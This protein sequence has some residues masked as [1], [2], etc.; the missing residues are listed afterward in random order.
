MTYSQTGIWPSSLAFNPRRLRA[1][2]PHYR[3]WR[4]GRTYTWAFKELVEQT[5]ASLFVIIGTSH[6]SRHRFT[7]TR[8]TSRPRSACP[9]DQEYIDRPEAHYGPACS[10]TNIMHLPEHSIELEV[11][12]LQYLLGKRPIR[13]MRWWWLVP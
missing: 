10:P 6:Y 1:V 5:T 13:I 11:V 3:L 7:L 9:T 8:N 4:G 2:W 12:L